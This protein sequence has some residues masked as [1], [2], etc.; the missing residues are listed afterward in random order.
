MHIRKD[1]KK[2]GLCYGSEYKH[3]HHDIW[4]CITSSIKKQHMKKYS[5][6]HYI[7]IKYEKKKNN[8]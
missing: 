1:F 5:Q 3:I 4:L 7:R 8:T 6:Y 2:N